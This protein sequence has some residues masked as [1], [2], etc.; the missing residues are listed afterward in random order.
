[1]AELSEGAMGVDI[2]VFQNSG[3]LR[4]K[5]PF[6]QLL[7]LWPLAAMVMGQQPG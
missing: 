3:S 4:L 6:L 2:C 5:I 1:M 7:S